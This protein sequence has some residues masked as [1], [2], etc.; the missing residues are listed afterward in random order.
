ME[1][2]VHFGLIRT[3]FVGGLLVV[4]ISFFFRWWFGGLGVVWG[5]WRRG[6]WCGVFVRGDLFGLGLG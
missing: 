6:G 5:R 1:F 2:V 3:L 4:P